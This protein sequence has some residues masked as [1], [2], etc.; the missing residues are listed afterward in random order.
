MSQ[1]SSTTLVPSAPISHRPAPS[2][3]TPVT[4]TLDRSTSQRTPSKPAKVSELGRASTTRDRDRRPNNSPVAGPGPP[5]AQP[6]LAPLQKTS[7]PSPVSSCS[8]SESA[9]KPRGG[10]FGKECCCWSGHAQKE[11]EEREGQGKGTRYCQ[12]A[13]TNLYR[14]R[15][16]EVIS[17][18]CQDWAGVGFILF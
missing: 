1:A 3:P 5:Q 17:K 7:K 14:C 2:P 18:S 16:H 12:E 8:S 6:Q 15:S 9:T 10:K 13:A 11:G 4:P